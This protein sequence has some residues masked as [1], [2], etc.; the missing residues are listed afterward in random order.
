[1]RES[2][3]RSHVVIVPTTTAFIEGFNMVLVE[4]LLAQRPVISS[5]VCPALEYVAGAARVVPPNDVDAY[6]QTIL[7]LADN[8]DAYRA[9]QAQAQL[10]S[11]RFLDERTSFAS[12]LRYTLSS[13]LSGRPVVPREIAIS[14]S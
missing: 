9:I 1:M 10:V 6:A 14:S 13:V 2:F 3:G 5:E 12:A 11:K 7:E 4:G 8:E